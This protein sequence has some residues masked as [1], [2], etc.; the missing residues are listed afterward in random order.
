VD[1][2]AGPDCV[3]NGDGGLLTQNLLVLA[4]LLLLLVHAHSGAFELPPDL[5]VLEDAAIALSDN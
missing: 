2:L 4:G 5:G 3:V 1:G